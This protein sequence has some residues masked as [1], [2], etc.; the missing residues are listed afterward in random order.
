MSS[1]LHELHLRSRRTLVVATL[2]VVAA[3]AAVLGVAPSAPAVPAPPAPPAVGHFV[4]YTATTTGF[5]PPQAVLLKNQF[6]PN[7]F[8]T[9]IGPTQMHCNPVKKTLPNGHTFPMVNPKAHLLCY[10]IQP[11]SQPPVRVIVTNQFGKAQLT[12]GQ[13]SSLCLPTW[14]NP[15]APTFPPAPQPPAPRRRPPP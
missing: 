14:K 7:G 1:L 4:C 6:S 3:G 8:T 10:A 13:P 15:T 12:T 9:P 2:G 5:D 11:S